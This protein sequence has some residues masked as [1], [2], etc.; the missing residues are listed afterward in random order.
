METRIE[1]EKEDIIDLQTKI[2][3]REQSVSDL[4]EQ[5]NNYRKINKI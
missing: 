1:V 4:K 5:I 3:Q 2:S